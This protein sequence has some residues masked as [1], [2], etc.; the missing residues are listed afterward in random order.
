[1]VDK[2]RHE[3]YGEHYASKEQEDNVKIVH[4]CISRTNST[5]EVDEILQRSQCCKQTVQ[6]SIAEKQNEV[7]IVGKTNAIVDPWTM[8]VHL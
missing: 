6:Q 5:P 3:T 1:M 2:Q 7:F 4:I 8:M